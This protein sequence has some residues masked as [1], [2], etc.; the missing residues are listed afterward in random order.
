[1]AYYTLLGSLQ[2]QSMG[3]GVNTYNPFVLLPLKGMGQ[4]ALPHMKNLISRSLSKDLQAQM[5]SALTCLESLSSA[6]TPF[7]V[8]P[9][10]AATNQFWPGFVFYVLTGYLTIAFLI[11]TSVRFRYY[12][13]G[14]SKTQ[15]KK[16]EY[17]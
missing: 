15:R 10:Y 8:N 1:M 4:I 17:R 16:V 11:V 6:A 13:V 7:L 12:P 2:L 3:F 14:F 9:I 5:F